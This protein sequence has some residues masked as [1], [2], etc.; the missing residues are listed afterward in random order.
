VHTSAPCAWQAHNE[1]TEGSLCTRRARGR[2]GEQEGWCIGRQEGWR[3]RGPY[4]NWGVHAQ[5]LTGNAR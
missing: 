2:I 1:H 5:E 4:G 3:R